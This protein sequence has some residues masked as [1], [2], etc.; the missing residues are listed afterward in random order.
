MGQDLRPAARPG[1]VPEAAEKG[2]ETGAGAAP[3]IELLHHRHRFEPPRPSEARGAFGTVG[4]SGSWGALTGA[5]G[6][7]F[8]QLGSA[9]G[10][11]GRFCDIAIGRVQLACSTDRTP[12]ALLPRCGV[13][14]TELF[15]D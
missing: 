8:V 12:A 13:Y 7:A 10:T 9:M 15:A 4:V 14:D 11:V 5:I 3:R 2:S 6:P 1:G